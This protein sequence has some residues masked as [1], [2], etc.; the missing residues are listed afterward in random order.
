[1]PT[2]GVPSFGRTATLFLL[3]L[4]LI[5]ASRS[6]HACP[7]NHIVMNRFDF[8]TSAAVVDT[9]SF[10]EGPYGCDGQ[11]AYD[12]RAGELFV[13]CAGGFASCYTNLDL[14]DDFRI[15][16]PPPGTP[17]S[18]QFV[19]RFRFDTEPG[20]SGGAGGTIEIRDDAGHVASL[21]IDS[22]MGPAKGDTTLALRLSRPA[23]EDFRLAVSIHLGAGE[24][25]VFVEGRYSFAGLPVHSAVTSCQGYVGP[26]GFDLNRIRMSMSSAGTFAYQPRSRTPGLEYPAGTGSTAVFQS[27]LWLGARVNGETRAAIAGRQDEFAPGS[28]VAGVPDD[29]RNPDYRVYKLQGSYPVAE[30]RDQALADYTLH[31]VPHGA[32]PVSVNEDGTLSITG[33]QML[34]H[35]YND[36]DPARHTDGAGHTAPLGVEVQQTTYGFTGPS[37][38]EDAV[39]LR[40]HIINKGATTLEDMHAALWSDVDLGNAT[41]D[42]SGCDSTAGLGYCYNGYESD[43]VYGSSPPAIGYDLLRGPATGKGGSPLTAFVSYFGEAN[44]SQEGWNFIRGL[45]RDGSPA[46]N[47]VNGEATRYFYSGDP[48]MGTGWLDASPIDRK[49]LLSTGPFTMAPGESQDIIAAILFGQGSD[50]LRSVAALRE[51]DTT[52]QRLFDGGITP[53]LASLVSAAAFA[54]HA[55]IVWQLGEGRDF[56]VA[57]DRKQ[58]EEAWREVG[59]ASPDGLGRITFDDHQ[60]EAGRAYA[61]RLRWDEGSR[62]ITAGEVLLTIPLA[63]D[64]ALEAILSNPASELRVR[65]TLPRAAPARIELFDVTGR[66]VLVREVGGLGPGRHVITLAPTPLSSGLYLLRLSQNGRM[67]FARAAVVH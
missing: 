44:N 5:A 21:A 61:Y 15:I 18:F 67:V 10:L 12:L 23:R 37:L 63:S 53:T 35:V 57:I 9:S 4:S 7:E 52:L 27:G 42:L 54:D 6:S 41:D 26:S 25:Q 45:Q 2:T 58:G 66:R 50:R 64:L 34:W 17:V 39:F 62:A 19:F 1:M 56:T 22:W 59:R 11:V 24:H 38:L 32:P 31:A 36:A 28:I 49:I 29:P 8:T 20:Y 3:P 51:A 13:D 60:V 46:V 55:H 43:A 65:F 16:G 40:F 30:L 33:E 47:P 48:V 14:Q